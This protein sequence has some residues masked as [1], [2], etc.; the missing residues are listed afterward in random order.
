MHKIGTITVEVIFS[1]TPP[2]T[3]AALVIPVDVQAAVEREMRL[4][5]HRGLD[6]RFTAPHPDTGEP[7]VSF[8]PLPPG[9]VELVRRKGISHGERF[10]AVF[11]V[12][13]KTYRGQ[14]RREMWLM[15]AKPLTAQAV[16]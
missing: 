10:R 12:L 16:A 5:L 11:H 8:M 6:H 3:T 7:T 15:D 9:R 14:P 13:E 4:L 1:H 2:N